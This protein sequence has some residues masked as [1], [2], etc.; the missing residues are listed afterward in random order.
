MDSHLARYIFL[1]YR[2]FMTQKEML[3]NRHFTGTIKVTGR[4]DAAA[5]QEAKNGPTH[6]RTLLSEDP[7]ILELVR[8][9][10]DV[11]ILQPIQMSCTSTVVPNVETSPGHRK[12]GSADSAGMT[13]TSPDPLA[14][15]SSC[16]SS[17]RPKAKR[18]DSKP[19]RREMFLMSY[20]ELKT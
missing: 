1:Y 7:E 10:L 20:V 17:P 18:R 19:R 8:D 11:F 13:G 2:Q 12:R 9:G 16:L 15:R 4:T 6:L 3:A 14:S 5:Q